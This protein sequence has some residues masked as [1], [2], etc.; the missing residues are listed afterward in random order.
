MEEP[1]DLQ[2]PIACDLTVFDV[3]ERRRHLALSQELFAASPQI[4]ELPDGF[5][6]LFPPEDSWRSKIAEWVKRERLCCPFLSYEIVIQASRSPGAGE[7]IELR[8]RGPKGAKELLRGE[9]SALG[10]LRAS[11]GGG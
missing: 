3:E 6:V 4:R 2:Q 10:A 5:A 11:G 7:G 9:L 1:G 8:L